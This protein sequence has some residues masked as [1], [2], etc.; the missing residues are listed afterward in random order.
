MNSMEL[1]GGNIMKKMITIMLLLVAF[2]W[3]SGKTDVKGGYKTVIPFDTLVAAD[4]VEGNFL[5]LF[6]EDLEG[7]VLLDWQVIN[8]N[9]NTKYKIYYLYG[10]DSTIMADTVL[11][12]SLQAEKNGSSNMKLKPGLYYKFYGITFGSAGD[13]VTIRAGGNFIR[14]K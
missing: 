14:I 4:T 9:A 8:I 13:S 11:L 10:N 2:V 12:D 3:L 7:S 5:Y 6:G 1:K